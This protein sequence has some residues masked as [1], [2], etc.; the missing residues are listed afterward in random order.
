[1]LVKVD[2][3][4]LYSGLLACGENRA[5]VNSSA[6]PY[7]QELRFVWKVYPRHPSL[8]YTINKPLN[9][10]CTP[11]S[12]LRWEWRGN[13]SREKVERHP[14]AIS[15]GLNLAHYFLGISKHFRITSCQYRFLPLSWTLS[16]ALLPTFPSLWLCWGTWA[17]MGKVTGGSLNWEASFGSK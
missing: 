5:A 3:A 17:E 14:P 12:L 6:L 15:K 16:F 8:E 11:D 13:K 7:P 10:P 2:V 9:V 1:M 4:S